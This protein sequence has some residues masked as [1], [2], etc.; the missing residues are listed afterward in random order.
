MSATF[1]LQD[2]LEALQDLSSYEIP[3]EH[4]LHDAEAGPLLQRA[5]LL[6]LSM[7][8]NHHAGVVGPIANSS[9][10][11]TD[12]DVFDIFR[13]L[14]KHADAVPG[15]C[16]NKLLDSI[17]SGF[18]AQLDAAIRDSKEEDQQAA[19]SHK[20]P[21]EMYAF[22]LNWFT[23]AADKVKSGG[24]DGLAQFQPKS[25]RGRGGKSGTSRATAKKVEEWTWADQ[26]PATLELFAKAMKLKTHRIWMTTPERDAFITYV[27]CSAEVC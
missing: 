4:D 9:D 15:P 25:R 27:L 12:P 21:L 5:Y 6:K 1:E 3:N 16:M 13:S 8:A 18:S 22:L 7:I 20:T 19:M 2:E 14:L 24:E 10:D 26:I 11:I 17:A 23:S